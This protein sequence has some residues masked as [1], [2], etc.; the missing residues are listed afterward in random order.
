MAY[1]YTT[2]SIQVECHHTTTRN[3]PITEFVCYAMSQWEMLI[4]EDRI[5]NQRLSQR[6]TERK[7]P[8][9]NEARNKD[10]INLPALSP[11]SVPHALREQS[12][13]GTK[14]SSIIIREN[15]NLKEPPVIT[16]R[17]GQQRVWF[18]NNWLHGKAW[19]MLLPFRLWGCDWVK[20]WSF[21]LIDWFWS[22][23]R[24]LFGNWVR[25]WD[26]FFLISESKMLCG[27]SMIKS[28]M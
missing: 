25:C 16:L 18:G 12:G 14:K 19:N 6:D 3:I 10:V 8:E 17:N 23:S 9:T 27:N 22:R 1:I 11:F 15:Y 2:I 7:V 24:R 21:G 20:Y 13:R 28:L 5:P 4:R 26:L